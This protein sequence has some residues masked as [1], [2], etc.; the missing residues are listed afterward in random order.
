[1]DRR[2]HRATK[3]LRA[4]VG[5]IEELEWVRSVDYSDEI[6]ERVRTVATPQLTEVMGIADKASVKVAK[7]K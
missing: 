5:E 3:S 7:M 2:R 4:S 6:V 1:M